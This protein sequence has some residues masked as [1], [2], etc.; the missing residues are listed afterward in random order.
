MSAELPITVTAKLFTHDE[1]ATY[2][3]VCP[4]TLRS[5]RQRGLIRYVALTP[6]KIYYRPEDCDA[7]LESCVTAEAYRPTERRRPKRSTSSGNVVSF[8]AGRRDRVAQRGRP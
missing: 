1:A 2:L 6:R 8:M 5:L 4:K 7:Y 3:R